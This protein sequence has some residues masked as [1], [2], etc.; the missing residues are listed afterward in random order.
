MY[1][2]LINPLKQCMWTVQATRDYTFMSFT[3]QI[4]RY[5]EGLLHGHKNAT[6]VIW[7]FQ[8]K[9]VNKHFREVTTRN[10]GLHLSVVILMSLLSKHLVSSLRLFAPDVGQLC[11]SS[12]H[13]HLGELPSSTNVTLWYWFHYLNNSRAPQSPDLDSVHLQEHNRKVALDRSGQANLT[14]HWSVSGLQSGSGE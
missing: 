4:R 11:T 2:T 14:R 12:Q 5:M 1:K 9:Y 7:S 13:V 8:L 3:L 10:S 6:A